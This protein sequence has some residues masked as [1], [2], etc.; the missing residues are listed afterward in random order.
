MTGPATPR[1]RGR[2]ARPH[3]RPPPAA[4]PLTVQ[5][6]ARSRTASWHPPATPPT[7]LRRPNCCEWSCSVLQS[8]GWHSA[9]GQSSG[10]CRRAAARTAVPV[11]PPR[12]MTAARARPPRQ[13]PWRSAWRSPCVEASAIRSPRRGP[14]RT[15]GRPAQPAA[16]ESPGATAA[17]AA[18]AASRATVAP[19]GDAEQPAGSRPGAPSDGSPL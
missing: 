19:A 3:Q 15:A 6:P 17:V 16:L 1:W 10:E 9:D 5:P 14:H 4:A 2:P 7:G 11:T 12:S 8:S 18:R 13:A